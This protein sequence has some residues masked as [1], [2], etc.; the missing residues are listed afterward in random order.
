MS[1]DVFFQP[2]RY[3]YST[4]RDESSVVL[5]G[6]QVRISVPLT[7]AEEQAVRSILAR[8]CPS[9]LDARC[10][11]VVEVAD[12]GSA[13]VFGK[14][15]R[16]GCVFT[17]SRLTPDLTRLL[18]DVLVAGNWVMLPAHVGPRVIVASMDA[19]RGEPEGFPDVV[20]CESAEALGALLACA[21]EL[22]ESSSRYSSGC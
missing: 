3:G 1:C 8:A 17:L 18:F 16:K 4:E 20:V 14:D 21:V 11:W 5:R 2:C 13:V 10:R 9:R 7:L 15:L 19:I 12:G 6:D 22:R